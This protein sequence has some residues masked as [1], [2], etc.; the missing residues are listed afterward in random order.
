MLARVPLSQLAADLARPDDVRARHGAHFLVVNEA[1][2]AL[3]ETSMVTAPGERR[4]QTADEAQADVAIPL[5]DRAAG[6]RAAVQWPLVVGRSEA[7]ALRVADASVS[8]QHARLWRDADGFA[9]EDL[10]SKNGTSVD[11]ERL[12]PGETRRI[13]GDLVVLLVGATPLWFADVVGLRRL[14][15][16]RR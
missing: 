10:S 2:L 6:P 16:S 1:H 9:F 13:R 7:C 14:L 4:P 12:R 15:A 3:V 8:K 11:G 5:D